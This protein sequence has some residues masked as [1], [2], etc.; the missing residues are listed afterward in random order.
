[1]K[2]TLAGLARDGVLSYGDGYRTRKDELA[3][4]GFRIIRVADVADGRVRM[5]SPD[6]VEVARAS[7]IGPKKAQAGDILLTTK[8]TVGRVAVMPETPEQAVYSPQLCFF[9]TAG[10]G[11]IDRSWLKSW[12]GS[13]EFLRQAAECMGKTDMAAYINLRDL[14]M[15][16]ITV[17]DRDEQRA[18]AEVLGALDNAISAQEKL[19]RRNQ[20]LVD[21]HATGLRAAANWSRTHMVRDVAYVVSGHSYRSADLVEGSEDSLITLKSITREG[22]YAARGLKPFAGEAKAPQCVSEGDLVVAQTDLTQAADVVGRAVRLP[23]GGLGGRRAVASL[24]LV[25]VRS[26]GVWPAEVVLAF[27]RSPGFRAHCLE[28]T[29]GTTVLHMKRGTVD[30]YGLPDVDAVDRDTFA[31][32]VRSLDMQRDGAM[33]EVT[34]LAAL[35]DVLLPELMS[36]RMRVKDAQQR[37]EEAI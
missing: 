25:I 7:A 16:S 23:R 22:E 11:V 32:T 27:L 31:A 8:G 1:M 5:E 21:A 3:N 15:M 12:F 9:R 14:G 36:G 6:F 30:T 13:P 20:E 10:N 17:P 26:R 33:L 28:R 34:R 4:S 35:R 2:T 24:D 29:S 19:I 37:V 18:I